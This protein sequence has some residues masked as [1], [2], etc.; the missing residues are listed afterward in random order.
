MAADW[1]ISAAD[2]HA[3]IYDLL[4]ASTRTRPTEGIITSSETFLP[5]Q[6][7][8]GVGAGSHRSSPDRNS[9]TPYRRS[10]STPVHNFDSSRSASFILTPTFAPAG[11]DG[12]YLLSY[13]RGISSIGCI[14]SNRIRRLLVREN[15]ASPKP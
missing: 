9:T 6:V 13:Q 5:M 4:V 7:S 14:C 2:G 12:C 11:Q 1:V 10:R 15:S 3:T 8:L